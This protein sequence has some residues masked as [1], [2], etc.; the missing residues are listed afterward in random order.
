MQKRSIALNFAGAVLIWA[1]A[2]VLSGIPSI[3]ENRYGFALWAV[4][5]TLGG[6]FLFCKALV[7]WTWPKG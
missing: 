5:A 1:G 4:L 3:A 6:G 7:G 2:I